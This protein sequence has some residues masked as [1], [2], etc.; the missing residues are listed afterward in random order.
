MARHPAPLT[1]EEFASWVEFNRRIQ[2]ALRLSHWT[3]NYRNE[4]PEDGSISTTEPL[5]ASHYA[6]M[7]PSRRLLDSSEFNPSE[8]VIHEWLHLHY[9]HPMSYLLRQCE[10]LLPPNDFEHTKR[11]A[12]IL[13]DRAIDELAKVLSLYLPEWKITRNPHE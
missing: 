3:V 1:D 5:E 6:T 13:E 11:E 4:A 8:V 9:Y 12:E 7:R 10:R 2:A